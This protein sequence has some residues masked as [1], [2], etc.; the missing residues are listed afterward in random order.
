M[1]QEK[2]SFTGYLLDGE[3]MLLNGHEELL[4]FDNNTVTYLNRD[5]TQTIYVSS[6]PVE[7]KKVQVQKTGNAYQSTS[8]FA[9]VTMPGQ[10][11]ADNGIVIGKHLEVFSIRNAALQAKC[12]KRKNIFGQSETCVVYENFFGD[13]PF[14]C[15]ANSFG[16]NTEIVIPERPENNIFSLKIKQPAQY[17]SEVEPDYIDFRNEEDL[18]SMLYTSIAVDSGG[19]WNYQNQI[20]LSAEEDG[21][22]FVHFMINKDFLDH[23]DTKYPVTLNQSVYIYRHKQP[24][25]AVY[26]QA[27][28]YARHYLSPYLLLGDNTPKGEGMALLRFEVL[29]DLDIDPQD[30]LKAEY[31]FTNLA[32]QEKNVVLGAYAV[33]NDWC[34]VN[35]KWKSRPGYD[36]L[37]AGTVMI[38]Q[39]GHYGLDIT[40]LVVEM[41]KNRGEYEPLYSVRNSFLI[42]SSSKESTLLLASGD[43]GFF[44]PYLKIILKNKQRKESKNHE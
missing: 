6:V 23:P 25:T 43:A 18:Q 36:R 29:E 14:F 4:R 39:K 24:D 11:D 2:V 9:P 37:P 20:V 38:R 32:D 19:K 7:E 35:T 42:K 41:L 13:V 10:I 21:T 8:G 31:C 28:E 12:F 1:K 15:Y 34:S 40:R 17:F 16:L 30:I 33:T 22:E 44:P 26:S 3:E 27:G 5:G